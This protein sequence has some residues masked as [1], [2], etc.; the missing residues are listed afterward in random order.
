MTINRKLCHPKMK[1]YWGV[2]EAYQ[3]VLFV[4]CVGGARWCSHGEVLRMQAEENCSH[5][6]KE[7][8]I[9]SRAAR[10]RGC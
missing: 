10:G 2:V 3:L 7:I 5:W 6:R 4:A 9:T 8:I 1:G